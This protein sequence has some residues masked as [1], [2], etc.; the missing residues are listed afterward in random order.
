MLEIEQRFWS[1][2]NRSGGTDSCWLWIGKSKQKGYGAFHLPGRVMVRA[3][4]YSYELAHG[5][6]VGGLHV[7]HRCDVR[8]CVNPAH[9]FLGTAGDNVRDCSA[10][11][12]FN[13]AGEHN[14]AARLTS[15]KASDIRSRRASG[16]T[17]KALAL[18]YGVHPN[19]IYAISRGEH[20]TDA[21]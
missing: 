20:W 11:G 2:V 7:L 5:P 3:H 4:R 1:K 18:E 12:R 6:I 13:H 17:G 16:E 10:K 21:S 8:L 19:T 9:L 14:A 15:A